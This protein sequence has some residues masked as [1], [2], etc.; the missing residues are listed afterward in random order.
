MTTAMLEREIDNLSLVDLQ[1]LFD[2]IA[3][4]KQA[5]ELQEAEYDEISFDQLNDETLEAFREIDEGGGMR[6]S[7]AEDLF[8]K[9]GI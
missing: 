8:A 9:L 1:R 7:S 4:K 2:Y 6:C 5:A 3:A